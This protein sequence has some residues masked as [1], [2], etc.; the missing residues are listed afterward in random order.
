MKKFT[1]NNNI[2]DQIKKERAILVS[3]VEIEYETL[4]QRQMIMQLEM[5]NS[6]RYEE[7]SDDYTYEEL[8]DL[9]EQMGKVCVGLTDEQIDSLPLE[10]VDSSTS[11]S[12]C[13]SSI[14]AGTKATALK[15]CHH[16]YHFDC[17]KQ[18][19]N[20][21]KTCPLCLQEIQI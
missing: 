15:P 10:R 13:L 21:N 7:P 14:N 12:I 11:C 5:I 16:L 1:D 3:Q 9:G 6:L 18:W 17:I 4:I 2:L 19:L 20:S 8:L